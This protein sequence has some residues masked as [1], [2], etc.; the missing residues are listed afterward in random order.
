MYSFG[1]RA[2]RTVGVGVILFGAVL[3]QGAQALVIDAATLSPTDIA[4]SGDENG[5]SQILAAIDQMGID[6]G[7]EFYKD[8]VSSGEEKTLAG[9]YETVFSHTDSH[10]TYATITYG[11]GLIVG[12]TAW[13]LIKDGNASPNWYLF[14]LTHEFL[15]DGKETIEARN[16][17]AGQGS[18]SHVSL[19]GSGAV[20]PGPDDQAVNEPATLGAMG[21]GVLACGAVLQ[22]RRR[23]A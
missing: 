13:L 2:L 23:N 6:V 22:R 9:S 10:P 21:L 11:S 1:I 8:N 14:D 3:S 19:F 17:F 12:P 7:T 20:H 4:A 16:F 15:W 18:I 5:T